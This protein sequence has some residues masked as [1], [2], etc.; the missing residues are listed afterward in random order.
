[1]RVGI[2]VFLWWSSSVLA[3]SMGHL[4]GKSQDGTRFRLSLES[5]NSTLLPQDN[6]YSRLFTFSDPPC[7]FLMGDNAMLACTG[8]PGTFLNG[9]LY[10]QAGTPDPQSRE[11][12]LE[13]L[14]GCSDAVPA[15]MQYIPVQC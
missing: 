7:V 8:L 11:V 4:E 1:M 9:T 10:R 13:C 5:I 14:R 12:E 15:M 6:A 3:E 2:L